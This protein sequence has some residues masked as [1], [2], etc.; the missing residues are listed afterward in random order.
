MRKPTDDQ[1]HD[2][3]D[4]WQD[5]ADAQDAELSSGWVVDLASRRVVRREAARAAAAPAGKL[6]TKNTPP[7]N[8]FAIGWMRRVCVPES[9]PPTVME[10]PGGG[11]NLPMPTGELQGKPGV[12]PALSRNCE[13]RLVRASQRN[14][15]PQVLRQRLREKGLGLS[16]LDF[17]SRRHRRPHAIQADH[18]NPCSPSRGSPFPGAARQAGKFPEAGAPVSIPVL[19]RRALRLAVPLALFALVAL[20][21]AC[22]DDATVP[23]PA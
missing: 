13:S 6:P 2:E 18:L 4:H 16:V 11:A 20:A 23:P 1:A 22:G 3:Q 8:Q 5:T 21:A 12:S 9:P 14:R 17:P 15:A 10:P 19:A 7:L